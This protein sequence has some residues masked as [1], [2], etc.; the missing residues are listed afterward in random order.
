MSI[1]PILWKC[2]FFLALFHEL[3]GF[4]VRECKVMLFHH[5][6]CDFHYCL[7]DYSTR[8]PLQATTSLLYVHKLFQFLP[9]GPLHVA[10]DLRV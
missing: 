5:V 1:Y 4:L 2:F 6:E 10:E 9:V 8:Q 3:V 7:F